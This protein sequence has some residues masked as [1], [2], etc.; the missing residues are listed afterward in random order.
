MKLLFRKNESYLFGFLIYAE[1][2]LDFGIEVY[3]LKWTIAL[4]RSV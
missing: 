3:L 1:D 4:E 2:A